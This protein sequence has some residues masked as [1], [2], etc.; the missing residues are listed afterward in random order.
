[1]RYVRR[2]NAGYVTDQVVFAVALCVL[3]VVWAASRESWELSAAAAAGALA[4][5]WWAVTRV[6]RGTTRQ[7]WAWLAIQVAGVAAVALV[8]VSTG[9]DGLC[10]YGVALPVLV[11]SWWLAGYV[12]NRRP[13]RRPVTTTAPVEARRAGNA[14]ARDAFGRKD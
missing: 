6:D 7:R 5:G 11:A 4:F 13:A 14:D 8:L 2:R 9:G 3:G 10:G 12:L 1:V